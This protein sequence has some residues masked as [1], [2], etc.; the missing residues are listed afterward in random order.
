MIDRKLKV[1]LFKSRNKDNSDIEGFKERSISFLSD[2]CPE[3][4]GER[5]DKFVN[6]GLDGELSRFYYSV[7]ARDNTKIVKSLQ[8]Y[9]IDHPNYDISSI[10]QKLA[11]I[12]AKK[13]NRKESKWMFDFD[14]DIS[15]LSEFMEDIMEVSDEIAIEPWKTPNGH[16]VVVSRGFDTRELLNKWQNVELKRDDL[17]CIKWSTKGERLNG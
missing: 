15:L 6:K 2:R 9:L 11:S 5:F 13:E 12:G 3:E 7:N 8:H 4:L 17:I 10:S 14:E 16:A 1:V